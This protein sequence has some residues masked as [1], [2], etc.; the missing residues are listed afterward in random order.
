MSPS[1]NKPSCFLTA[2][3]DNNERA[4]LRSAHVRM[5]DSTKKTA[6]CVVYNQL[7]I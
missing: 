5:D 3:G 7:I 2:P 1:A 6:H 4:L